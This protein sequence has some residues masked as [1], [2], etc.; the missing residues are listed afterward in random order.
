MVNAKIV[1]FLKRRY[2]KILSPMGPYFDFHFH[3]SLKTYLTDENPETRADCWTVLSHPVLM[4]QS[5]ASLDQ[6]WQGGLRLGIAVLYPLERPFTE[7]WFV[8]ELGPVISPLSK[9][10]L[11]KT[12]TE[13][14]FSRL[15]EELNHLMDSLAKYAGQGKE[16][17]IIDR[18]KDYHTDK[19]NLLL[20]IEGSH[21][22]QRSGYAIQ[23]TLR[24]LKYGKH[25]IFS[26]NLTHLTNFET[27]THAYALKLIEEEDFFPK[28]KGIQPA[29]YDIIDIAY[30]ES[31]N[32]RIL[33]DIKHMSLVSRRDFYT[34]R[35][36]KGYSAIPIL[37]THVACTGISWKKESLALYVTE[38]SSSSKGVKVRY[39]KPSGIGSGAHIKTAFNPWS[40]NIYDEEIIEILDSGGL[41]G[42]NLD[43][44]ILGNDS[45]AAEYFS[46]EEFGEVFGHALLPQP[47]T[48]A[49]GSSQP[50]AYTRSLSE[51]DP[52]QR[53]QAV[54]HLRHLCNQ[55]LHVVKIGG[56]RAWKQI[57][58]GSDFDGL[59]AP[60]ANC[61]SIQEYPSLEKSVR[62]ML[63]Q[64]IREAKDADSSLDFE[65]GRSIPARVRDL[66]FNNG[67]RFIRQHYR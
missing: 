43:K 19:I 47:E 37:A 62:S 28:G 31:G 20:S 3:T 36:R 59:I 52:D 66:M 1:V 34:Y 55:I 4:L 27:C 11:Q 44:R 14:A 38:H 7:S 60:I 8:S 18:Y 10:M 48:P 56:G 23:E 33:I 2:L 15:M 51:E 16:A 35:K 57:C 50:I 41:I 67:A 58:L 61:I 32:R 40:V 29:G 63:K 26:M 17:R 42:F 13:D 46:A 5:Q 9:E 30:E 39:R 54:R 22:L 24:E 25:R 6:A 64:M 49:V 45:V 65:Q 53:D 12:R 21:C